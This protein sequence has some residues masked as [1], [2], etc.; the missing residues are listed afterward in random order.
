MPSAVHA[1]SADMAVC[2]GGSGRVSA[3]MSI[4]PAGMVMSVAGA[5]HASAA[6]PCGEGV[7]DA[8]PVT[9]M[10]NRCSA[11]RSP[12][13]TVNHAPPSQPSAAHGGWTGRSTAARIAPVPL[14]IPVLY[15][16]PAT[17]PTS[18]S[19]AKLTPYAST[20]PCS[21]SSTIASSL[22]SSEVALKL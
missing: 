13:S 18:H 22:R 7:V 20:M 14:V 5:T 11:S 17:A 16:F 2:Q 12:S 19:R 8:R 3:T 9:S 15:C 21:E 4:V 6:R 10:H 1:V